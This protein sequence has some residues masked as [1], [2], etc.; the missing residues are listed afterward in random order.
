MIKAFRKSVSLSAAKFRF[1]LLLD[2]YYSS[3]MIL[4]FLVLSILLAISDGEV[5]HE[6]HFFLYHCYIK[7]DVIC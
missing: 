3:D 2:W 1:I 4:I 6:T 7:V 5:N